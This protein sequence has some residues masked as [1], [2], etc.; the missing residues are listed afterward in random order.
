MNLFGH[1]KE[2]HIIDLFMKGDAFAMDE[3]YAEYADYLTKVCSQYIENQ[4]NLPVSI[5]LSIGERAL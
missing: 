3:L 2:Q 1:N 5:H 4:E